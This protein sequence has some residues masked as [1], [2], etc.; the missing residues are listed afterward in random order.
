MPDFDQMED[1][2]EAKAKQEEP[3]L[4]KKAEDKGEAE[5]KTGGEKLREEL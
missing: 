2:A 1:D 3:G 5:A 4:E